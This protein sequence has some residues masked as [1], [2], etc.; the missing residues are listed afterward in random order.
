[1]TEEVPRIRLGVGRP[2]PGRDPADYVLERFHKSELAA[3]DAS[4]VLGAN[5]V[6]C[7][8]ADGLPTAMNRF[9]GEARGDEPAKPD[10]PAKTPPTQIPPNQPPPSQK[11]PGDSSGRPNPP[12]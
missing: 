3:V 7:W 6:E 2:A 10:K 4:V 11:P 12:R 5:A 8:C 9:N 1:R